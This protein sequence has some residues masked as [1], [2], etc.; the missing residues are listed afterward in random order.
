MAQIYLA[1]NY[2]EYEGW[3]L[4]PFDTAD[5]AIQAV[6]NGETDGS[7]WKILKE[8]DVIVEEKDA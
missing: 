6:K 4:E 3:K 5:E 2:G 7:G 1:I 8:L